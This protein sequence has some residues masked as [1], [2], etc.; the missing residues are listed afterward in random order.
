MGDANV[1]T[2]EEKQG[3]QAFKDHACATCHV[4]RLWEASLLRRW[5]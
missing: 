3:Y 1:L 5:D 2:G 4:G